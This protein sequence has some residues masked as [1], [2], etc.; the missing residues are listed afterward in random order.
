[1]KKRLVTAALSGV[2]SIHVQMWQLDHKE[3]WA[4][5]NWCFQTVVLE[6]TLENLLDRKLIKPVN[7]KGN[8]S[9]RLI[10]MTD[11]EAEAPILQPPD[12]NSQLIGKDADA[13]KDWGK[14]ESGTTEDELV[15][16]HNWLS[17]HEFEQTHGDNEGQGG[18]TC[19]SSWGHK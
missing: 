10:G 14:E 17:G 19:C 7:P 2:S 16:W 12:A 6:K 4:L 8:Q 5:K 13:G 3:S 18:L 1:M 11:I 9:W 15:R